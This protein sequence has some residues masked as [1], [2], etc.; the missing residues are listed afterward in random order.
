MKLS[1]KI[2]TLL[3]KNAETFVE[4]PLIIYPAIKNYQTIGIRYNKEK[5]TKESI[6]NLTSHLDIILNKLLKIMMIHPQIF[7]Y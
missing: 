4:Y 6:N 2:N 5:F 7:Q 3:K 1:K